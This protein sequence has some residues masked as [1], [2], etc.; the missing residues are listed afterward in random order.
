M[1]APIAD[2]WKAWTNPNHILKWFGSDP[3][4]TGV[5]ARLDVQSGGAFEVSFKNGD[6]TRHTCYGIYTE[7]EEPNKLTFTWNWRSEPGVESL[8]RVLLQ[9]DGDTTEMQFQHAHVG[10]ESA[11][12]YG[13]GWKSTF[14]KLNKV[15]CQMDS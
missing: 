13:F 2:V 4:G 14:M 11:H 5:E 15:L 9:Q 10:H 3:D 1:R 6:G 8:V 12:D 7:V